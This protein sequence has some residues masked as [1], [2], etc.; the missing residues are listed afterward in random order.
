MSLTRAGARSP[1]GS[2]RYP[3][4]SPG[5]GTVGCT[6]LH[7]PPKP[8][9]PVLQLSAGRCVHVRGMVCMYPREIGHVLLRSIRD[10]DEFVAE[11]QVVRQLQVLTENF[12]AI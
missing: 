12:P 10:F 2:R 5:A 1:G 4:L 7:S 3:R 11:D 9:R 8:T 6:H